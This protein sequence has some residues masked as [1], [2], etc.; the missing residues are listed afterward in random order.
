MLTLP[1]LLPVPQHWLGTEGH[2][3]LRQE[4]IAPGGRKAV[5]PS[6]PTKSVTAGSQPLAAHPQQQSP[7]GCTQRVPQPAAQ[8]AAIL[9]GPLG[10]GS[11]TASA[12]V[13]RWAW[14][15][16]GT[17][18]EVWGPF[19]RADK[20]PFSLPSC[21]PGRGCGYYAHLGD[22]EESWAAFWRGLLQPEGPGLGV[23][24]APGPTGWRPCSQLTSL[25]FSTPL[26]PRQGVQAWSSN[27]RQVRGCCERPCWE[28]PCIWGH[29]AHARRDAH[30]CRGN[31]PGF[32]RGSMAGVPGPPRQYQAGAGEGGG[33]CCLPHQQGRGAA[34]R[35]PPSPRTE[36]GL[37]PWAGRPR[38]CGQMP[39]GSLP[40]R[41][42]C[43]ML[44]SKV[45]GL[46]R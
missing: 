42:A 1:L 46:G 36:R 28:S 21:C 27:T 25:S 32:L 14:T 4:V 40:Q 41:P 11:L 20:G 6:W 17:A 30:R 39:S 10:A 24:L 33:Q 26:P 3:A 22:S 23:S 37:E 34:V 43:R 29:M 13:A 38:G 12:Q 44:V 45:Q 19:H 8:R 35:G 9:L 16:L 7:D 31:K 5:S 15:T 18:L 2:C